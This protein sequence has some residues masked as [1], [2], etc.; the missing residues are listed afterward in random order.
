MLEKVK[1]FHES[2]DIPTLKNPTLISKE[3]TLLRVSL[4][5]E[6]LRELKEAIENNDLVE[7]A[8]ALVDLEYV[9]LGAALE[10]GLTN[11]FEELFNEV[12]K[13][14][15]SKAC[16]SE[17][18]AIKTVEFYLNRDNTQSSYTVK[19][20]KFV[21]KRDDDK[22]LKSINYY[23][24]DLKKILDKNMKTQEELLEQLS[25]ED[26]IKVIANMHDTIR[27]WDNGW[28]LNDYESKILIEVGNACT[29]NCVKNNDWELPKI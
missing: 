21:V 9:V 8:D 25:K 27:E 23:P 28:G 22:L 1:E 15:M 20:D 10:F 16:S 12:H 7:V 24:A 13:S 3:R 19:G 26:L 18:E 14:N 5:E 17:E 29:K 6:E 2:F 4:I 11:V